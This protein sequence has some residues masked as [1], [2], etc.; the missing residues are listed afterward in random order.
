[1]PR[2][3]ARPAIEVGRLDQVAPW[4]SGGT[5]IAR[6]ESFKPVRA[7]SSAGKAVVAR[8]HKLAAELLEYLKN[9]AESLPD[10]GRSVFEPASASR[11][12]SESEVNELIYKRMSKSQQ[13]RWPGRVPPPLSARSHQIG[14]S[15]T[16]IRPPPFFARKIFQSSL[17]DLDRA[18]QSALTNTPITT[19]ATRQAAWV[20]KTRHLRFPF[21]PQGAFTS[22]NRPT[23]TGRAFPKS[24][25]GCPQ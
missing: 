8:T 18:M 16:S 9:N 1:M 21:R 19:P 11:A 5:A 10:Y 23:L 22:R 7:S 6:L 3:G 12:S 2:R 14:R 15:R 13:M 24:A 25:P 17:G 4:H 20:Q